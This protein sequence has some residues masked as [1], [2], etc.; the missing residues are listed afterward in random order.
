MQNQSKAYLFAGLTILFWSTVATAFKLALKTQSGFQVLL[1]SSLTSTIFLFIYLLLSGQLSGIMQ[2][3]ARQLLYSAFLGFINPFL[4]YLILFR[5]Y[6]NLP[7]QVAQPLNMIWPIV[8]VLIS[9]PILGQKITTKSII[10]LFISFAGII[11]VSSQGGGAE[12]H[13]AQVPY[14]LLAV[15]TSLI[16]SVFWILNMRD[17]RNESVKL[18]LNFFFAS[19]YLLVFSGLTNQGFPAEWS[20]YLLD[21]YIGLFEMGLAFLFWLKAL[22]FSETTDK[23][24]NL[25]FIFPFI[26]LIFIHFI[27]GEKIHF[28]TIYGL[29]LVVT[30]I[31]LQRLKIKFAK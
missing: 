8:L 26:S 31:L 4:Y 2:S 23:I 21:I 30:G 14:M 28:T 9:I 24:S 5:A 3:N 20:D 7:A 11:L 19:I 25:V 27:L 17:K 29:M 22:Q 1:I 12:F 18:F 13:R 10:A 16:W 6:A 15:S